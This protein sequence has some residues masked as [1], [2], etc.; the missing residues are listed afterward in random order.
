[1]TP[2][3]VNAYYDANL[4][5]MVFPAGIL[6]PPF[7]DN[8][9]PAG[10]N[11]GAIGLV[12]GHELTHGFDDEGRQFDGDGNLKDWWT[13]KVGAEFDKRAKCLV[14]QF[15]GYVTVD[16]VHVNGQLTLGENIADLG[17][18]KLSYAA[19][20]D[21]TAG[22]A[23][24]TSGKFTPDQTYFLGFAQ[25]WC[26]NARPE[27]KRTMATV[28]PHAPAR[29]RVNGPISNFAPFAEA[30]QCKAGKAMVKANKCEVW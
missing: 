18:L 6:Q 12:M 15:D 27:Y 28:D 24:E 30:F 25:A 20:K 14:D 23:A 4:N 1:M 11:Y 8:A 10:S 29:F 19:F 16:D 26:Q 5:E 13:K 7:F 22:K 3:T 9:A 2:P 21:A 17:G